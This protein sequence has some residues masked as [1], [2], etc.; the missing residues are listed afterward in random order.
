[1]GLGATSVGLYNYYTSLKTFPEAIRTELRSA[2]RC[3][4]SQDYVNANKFFGKAWDKIIE[5]TDGVTDKL[6]LLK[7]TG[8]AVSWSEML[9]EAGRRLDEGGLPDPLDMAYTVLCE[10]YDYSRN[11]IQGRSSAQITIPERL[12]VVAL[13]VKLSEL[14]EGQP[15]LEDAT[16]QQL[17]WAV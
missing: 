13:A 2:L 8:V 17:T 9:E 5:N 14:A 3:K 15:N 12:R 6:D 1:M 10:G 16:E 4:A 11:Y 7:I